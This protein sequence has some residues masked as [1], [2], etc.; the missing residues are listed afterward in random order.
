MT[1]NDSPTTIKWTGP[2]AIDA[3]GSPHAYHLDNKSG[4]DYLANAGTPGNW[5]GIVTD[6]QGNP[7]IQGTNDPAPGFCVSPTSF[8]DKTK[9]LRDPLRY[10]N[11]ETVPYIAVPK[12][13]WKT[14]GVK[15][16]D[17]CVVYNQLT[18]Q[19]SSGIVADIGPKG[20]WGEASMFMAKA[21]GITN[22][23]PKNGGASRGIVYLVFKGSTRPWPRTNADID[24]QAQELL[25]AYGGIDKLK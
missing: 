15:L 25:L 11:S 14:M 17:V 21:V 24:K 8:G 18:K 7:I 13:A 1:I 12:E 4:L 6:S 23:S 3:D 20:R 10:V 9:N 19:H 22:N 2:M 5:Y 16:G